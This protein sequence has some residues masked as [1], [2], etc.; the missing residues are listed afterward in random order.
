[1]T[2]HRIFCDCVDCLKKKIASLNTETAAL[3]K[4]LE[5]RRLET[6]ATMLPKELLDLWTI[7]RIT[8]HLE[9]PDDVAM[10]FGKAICLRLLELNWEA[11][12]AEGRAND[13]AEDFRVAYSY[14]VNLKNPAPV[15]DTAYWGLVGDIANVVRGTP[16]WENRKEILWYVSR[17]EMAGFATTA[18]EKQNC[19]LRYMAGKRKV[20]APGTKR[21]KRSL[22][23]QRKMLKNM[24]PELIAAI[25]AACE[26]DLAKQVMG[27]N[28]KAINALLGSVL[29]AHKAPAA[30]VKQLLEAK[31]NALVAA[32]PEAFYG[33]PHGAVS[34]SKVGGNDLTAGETAP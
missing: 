24:P 26:S 3:H 7:C 18:A 23:E 20:S 15:Y 10:K 25:S 12:C 16:H 9:T 2:E 17:C 32:A 22:Q 19:A 31:L 8:S 4:L 13:T 30:L 5:K 6:W 27:G 1:M 11:F 21:R 29:K 33:F 14:M 34:A 28:A